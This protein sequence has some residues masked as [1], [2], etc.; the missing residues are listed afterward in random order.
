[1]RA[2][3]IGLLVLWPMLA[4]AAT[5]DL[6]ALLQEVREASRESAA[7]NAEREARFLDNKQDQ[8]RLLAEARAQLAPVKERTGALRA[9]SAAL[10]AEIAALQKK[11]ADEAGDLSQMVAV[12]RSAAG[13]LRAVVHDS[14]ITAQFPER[15]ARLAALAESEQVPTAAEVQDLWFLL[16][17]AMTA[18]GQVV[19]FD[20]PVIA[21]DGSSAPAQVTRVGPF[22][23]V[24]G[25]DYLGYLPGVG[26]K[27]L[28]PQ[29][30]GGAQALAA[31]FTAAE[32]G[33][34]PMAI[35]PTRGSI[36]ALLGQRPGL[37]ERIHQGGAI[38]YVTI[39]LGVAGLLLAL[40]QF[41]RLI[42]VG[43]RVK[44][45]LKRPGEP[46]A[47]N[48]LGRVLQAGRD[49]TGED[50]EGMELKLDEA[51]LREAPRLQRSLPLIKLLAAVAPLL[52]LLGTVVG[53]IATFQAITFFGAG[54]PQ[55]LAGGISQ[56]LVTT[57]LGLVVA[58]P[59]LF[60]HSVLSARSRA[61]I[62]ILE[63]QSAGLLA[64]HAEAGAINREGLAL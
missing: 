50:P 17:Q 63:E 14:V 7:I 62:Q 30:G 31:K 42:G 5:A 6:D 35:D 40:L 11:L 32:S 54:D 56:A 58:I 48:P 16:Q 61:L 19:T 8:A 18:T 1:M 15:E 28:D 57:V 44:R 52:G 41:L 2:L 3:A 46:K 9:R 27:R 23:A 43:A 13:N 33:L 21:P 4:T 64:R 10:E 22:V 38:G 39:A 24:A 59:L 53:M 25:E 45:Q 37:L 26:L 51:V 29:P 47:S 55:V 12:M 49:A 60:A 20:A 36:L 34:V